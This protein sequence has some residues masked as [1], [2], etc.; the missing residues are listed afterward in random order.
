MKYQLWYQGKPLRPT[1][2]PLRDAQE[3][4]IAVATKA[5]I[6]V[7]QIQLKEQTK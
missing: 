3:M 6:P 5:G 4:R 7:Q 1:A 2:W